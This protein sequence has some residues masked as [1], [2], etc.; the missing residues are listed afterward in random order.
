MVTIVATA[1]VV[2]LLGLTVAAQQST[3]ASASAVPNLITYGG[4][5]KDAG[6][7]VLVTLTGVTFLL[8]RDQQGGAPLW[9]DTQNVAPD[10]SGHYTVQL[11]ASSQHSLPSDLFKSGEARWL[12]LQIAGEAEQERVMLVAAPYALKSADAETLGGLPPSAFVLATPAYAKSATATGATASENAS[13]PTSTVT[14][15]GGTAGTFPMFNTATDIENSTITQTGSGTSAKV[16]IGTTTPA[17]TLDVKGGITA[18]GTLTLGATGAATSSI[19]KSS[20]PEN[21]SASSFNSSTNSA[22]SQTFQLK[23]EPSGNNTA[24]PSGTLNLLFGAGG[25]RQQK[26]AS[27][28]QAMGRSPL[29]PDRRSRVR[30]RS[31][32]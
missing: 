8:Y 25:H 14:T 30:A 10:K 9:M 1:V 7:R 3:S 18:R 4:V 28:F 22:V 23:A 27:S 6:G 26:L 11:G 17:T 31:R 24:N 32:Q 21:I 5:L 15:S 13:A 2:C 19:G 16:G 12:A 29:P 20:Q